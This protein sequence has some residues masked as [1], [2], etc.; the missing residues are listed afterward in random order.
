MTAASRP[1]GWPE[2]PTA[3]T[4]PEL[5]RR[6]ERVDRAVADM[7][8]ELR[9]EIRGLAFVPAQVWDAEKR[10]MFD[11]IRQVQEAE[12]ARTEGVAIDLAETRRALE[13]QQ[14]RSRQVALAIAGS[15]VFPIIVAIILFVLLKGGTPA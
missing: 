12:Q 11:R 14:D 3:V 13:R 2:D 4:L 6:L 9:D 7:R 15:F 8:S 1:G 10:A 5:G